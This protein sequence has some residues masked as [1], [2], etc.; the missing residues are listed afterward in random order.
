MLR[1]RRA[2]SGFCK[3][4]PSSTPE[5]H[6]SGVI[7]RRSD[8]QIRHLRPAVFL[9][10]FF[11]VITGDRMGLAIADRKKPCLIHVLMICEVTHHT[12]G[13]AHGESLIISVTANAIGMTLN[14]ETIWTEIWRIEGFSELI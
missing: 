9:P 10:A 3:D 5:S 12:I 2:L 1:S 4:T 8:I 14:A 6:S 13:P 11:C 7:C